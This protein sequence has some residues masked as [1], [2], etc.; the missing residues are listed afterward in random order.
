MKI[1]RAM[2]AVYVTLFLAGAAGAQQDQARKGTPAARP[3]RAVSAQAAGSASPVARRVE[4]YLRNLYA[5]GP[6]FNV[7]VGEPQATP[8][9]GLRSVGVEITTEDQVNNLIMYVSED[10][11]FLVQGELSD[12]QADPFAKI[13]AAM[14]LS[15]AAS[16]GPAD[17]K[18][19]VVE[20]ADFQCP[21]CRLLS[22][23]LRGIF[24]DYPQVRFVFRDFPLTQIHAWALTAATAGR[25]IYHKNPAAFW[26]YADY[27]YDRQDKITADNVWETVV[28]QGVAA[29]Y[30][31]ADFKACMADPAMKAEID[32]SIAEGEELKIA[33]TP[34]VFVNG[35]R[36]VGGERQVLVQ[37]IDYELGQTTKAAKP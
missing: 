30:D 7:K 36:L 32:K 15:A 23:S 8:I 24:P 31:E 33:N 9:P 3:G 14:D 26:T 37:F 28:Q 27:I 34:T 5:L 4:A 17:A 6:K 2:L 16:R 19:V 1:V 20:Y 21:S 11:R 12:M 35:R 25:C 29:G 22:K 10:G 18:V 13:R